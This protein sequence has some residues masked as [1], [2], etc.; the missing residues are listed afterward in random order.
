MWGGG[1]RPVQA[2]YFL[3]PRHPRD[4]WRRYSAAPAQY[5]PAEYAP[6]E[7]SARSGARARGASRGASASPT[8]FTRDEAIEIVPLIEDVLSLP[9]GM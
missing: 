2:S 9:D 1:G 5:A 6:A 4:A 3:E 8:R 7:A